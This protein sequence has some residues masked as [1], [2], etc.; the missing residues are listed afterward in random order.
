MHKES[1]DRCCDDHCFGLVG[2][3]CVKNIK[4]A[5]YKGDA[6]TSL[7]ITWHPCDFR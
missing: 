6:E 4:V 7:K 3:G 1:Q 2:R 5:L